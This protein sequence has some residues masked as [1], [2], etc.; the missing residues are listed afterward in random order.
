MLICSPECLHLVAMGGLTCLSDLMSYA[1]GN[2]MFLVGL[3][4]PD[5]P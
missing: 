5:R 2:F 4:K 3:P 1:D